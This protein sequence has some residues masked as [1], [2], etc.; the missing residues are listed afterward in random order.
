M[1]KPGA[2]TWTENEVGKGRRRV[3]GKAAMAQH[4]PVPQTDTGGWGEDPKAGGRSIAKELGKT[5]P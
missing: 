2:A 4:A 3:P 5:A 1:R